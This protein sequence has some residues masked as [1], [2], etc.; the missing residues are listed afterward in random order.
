MKKS[1]LAVAAMTAFAG[2]AHAQSSVQIFGIM[3]ES[4]TSVKATDYASKNSV[5]QGFK[6]SAWTSNRF[7]FRLNEDLGGGTST[8]A[9]LESGMS[10]ISGSPE[11]AGLGGTGTLAN[12][13]APFN[14]VR[15]AYLGLDNKQFGRMTIGYMYAPEYFQRITNIGGTANTLG[16]AATTSSNVISVVARGSID[17]YN[18]IRYESPKFMGASVI[19]AGGTANKQT[20]LAFNSAAKLDATSTTQY[21]P[22][23]LLGGQAQTTTASAKTFGVNWEAGKAKV[24][25]SS[26][27]ETALNVTALNYGS[28]TTTLTSLLAL[29]TT[30]L[31]NTLS[32]SYD[33]G[34]VKVMGFGAQRSLKNLNSAAAETKDTVYS[35]GVLAPITSRITYGVNYGMYKETITGTAT[36]QGAAAQTSLQYAFS[37]R[38]TAYLLAARVWQTGGAALG[39]TPQS[40]NQYTAGLFHSF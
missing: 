32:G 31:N 4:Y 23:G 36:G 16:V 5:T 9:Y 25:F 24:Q 6:D 33:F 28:G 12:A 22:M 3:D 29:N 10:I 18:G 38:T 14:N 17:Q 20:D 8:V 19:L 30:Q 1:L 7:G 21:A 37:K 35:L 27:Q 13:T 2:A 15:E 11:Q 40:A 34:V 26:T 39:T